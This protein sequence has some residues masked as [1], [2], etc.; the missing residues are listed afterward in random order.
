MAYFLYTG[1]VGVVRPVNREITFTVLWL[2]LAVLGSFC[3][4][5]YADGFRRGPLL[6]AVRDWLPLPLLLLAY[7]EMGWFVLPHS[8]TGLEQSWVVD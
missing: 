1:V 4:L 8:G 3:L 5:A 7:K 2:N 6:G